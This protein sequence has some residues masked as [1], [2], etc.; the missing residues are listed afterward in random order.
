MDAAS[1]LRRCEYSLDAGN[2]IPIE[3]ADGVIDSPAEKF[4]IRLEN[5]P[6]GEHVLVIR[7]VDGGNN[8]GLIKIV[9]R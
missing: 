3:A 1:A 8:S 9:L 7:A 5:L 2:W 4:L 6:P